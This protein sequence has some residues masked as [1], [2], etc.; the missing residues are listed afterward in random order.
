M[1]YITVYIIDVNVN[2]EIN[3]QWIRNSLA[4]FNSE[5]IY[6][7]YSKSKNWYISSVICSR[8]GQQLCCFGHYFTF[9]FNCFFCMWMGVW[10]VFIAF[11][12]CSQSSKLIMW[13]QH[14]THSGL[15]TATTDLI[16]FHSNFMKYIV[17][18]MQSVI[19]HIPTPNTFERISRQPRMDISTFHLYEK[20]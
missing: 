14:C 9:I 2:T 20:A 6:H 16:Y 7:F 13:V 3:S 1:L 15:N 8:P 19:F 4:K 17:S 11:L 5:S 10:R 12:S 18:I